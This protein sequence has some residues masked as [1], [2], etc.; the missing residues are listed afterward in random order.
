MHDALCKN[1]SLGLSSPGSLMWFG[2]TATH[3]VKSQKLEEIHLEK[4]QKK[5]QWNVLRNLLY[6]KF[7]SGVFLSPHQREKVQRAPHV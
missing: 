5:N 1:V 6:S 3:C 2:G 7:D 4:N